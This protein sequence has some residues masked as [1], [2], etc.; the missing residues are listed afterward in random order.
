MLTIHLRGYLG[1]LE[2]AE[3]AF[4]AATELHPQSAPA[5]NN[6]SQ[7]FFEQGRKQE[8]LVAAKKAVALKGPL[9]SAAEKTLQESGE[10]NV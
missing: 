4:R 8:A 10:H 2:G 5:F 6:L 1:D 3:T 9:K 7:V